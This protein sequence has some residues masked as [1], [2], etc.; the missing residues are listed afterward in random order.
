MEHGIA[1]EV[2]Q[3]VSSVI[4]EVHRPCHSNELGRNHVNTVMEPKHTVQC[5]LHPA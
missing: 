4:D 2:D 1:H 3:E 5:Y